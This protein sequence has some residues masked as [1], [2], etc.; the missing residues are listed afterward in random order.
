[1]DKKSDSFLKTMIIVAGVAV[2]CLISFLVSLQ[3]SNSEG[4]SNTNTNTTSSSSIIEKAQSESATVNDSEMKEFSQI[5]V[6]R[7]LDMY[8][9]KEN[10]VVLVARPT[11]S[12][13]QIAEP[14]I[15]NIAYKYDIE[16][17]YLN[18][19]DFADDDEARFIQSDEL[20]SEGY[21]TPMLLLVSNNEIVDK[22]DGL[23]DMDGYVEFFKRNNIISE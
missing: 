2:V 3:T 16:I 11:C 19:D 7:Y 20:F 17:N 8:A 4:N 23:A 9:G 18:T 21:G 13:C 14:I 12:Y 6:D 10:K 1:M 15:K 5:D 22:V